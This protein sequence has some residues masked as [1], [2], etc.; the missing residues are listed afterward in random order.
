MLGGIFA[1]ILF[2][3]RSHQL[4]RYSFAAPMRAR[5]A[6]G[7]EEMG[8][9]GPT[10]LL[11]S[12]R[13]T[14]WIAQKRRRPP[15]TVVP[16]AMRDICWWCRNLLPFMLLLLLPW[17]EGA[18]A[19]DERTPPKRSSRRFHDP[20]ATLYEVLGVSKH[21]S[22]KE[23]KRVYRDLALVMHPDKLGPLLNDDAAVS[24]AND[25]FVKVCC[26]QLPPSVTGVVL[27]C[28]GG[29]KFGKRKKKRWKY[30][31]WAL[32]PRSTLRPSVVYNSTDPQSVRHSK[33][34]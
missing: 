33:V 17:I 27:M 3:P 1:R 2:S 24:E 5:P 13:C 14:S 10:E 16:A 12:W 4:W 30:T 18:A 25:V 9:Q 7:E 29:L 32:V 22:R 11:A 31:R 28:T 8:L 6:G 34:S 21:S 20:K 19:A 26:R 15:R 23:I